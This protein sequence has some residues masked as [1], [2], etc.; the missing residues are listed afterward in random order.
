MKNEQET[1]KKYL[2]YMKKQE[3]LKKKIIIIT[4]SVSGL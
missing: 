4:I 3:Y 2:A 1:L